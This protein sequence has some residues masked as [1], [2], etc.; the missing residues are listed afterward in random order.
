MQ[1]LAGTQ[2]RARPPGAP[3]LCLQPRPG[4]LG[5]TRPTS[6]AFTR[7]ELLV[8]LGVLALLALVVLPALA[9]NR[10]RSARVICAN[11]PRQIGMAMQL[12]GNDHD[13]RPP[14]E[15]ELADGGTRRHA[16]A[17][18]TWLHFAWLS[19]ELAS[20]QLLLCPADSGK[21]ARDFTGDPAGGY[22]HP[23]F[24]N[25]ATS[26]ALSHLDSTGANGFLAGD[27][28]LR[29][30]IGIVGCSV[31]YTGWGIGLPVSSPNDGW[32]NGLHQFAGNYLT[33][34]GAVEQADNSTLRNTLNA[35]RTDIGSTSLHFSVPR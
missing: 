29:F 21:P 7:T 1:L 16:L 9:N 32:T 17:A 20:P 22:L 13:D 31:F 34:D 25:R 28:N 19:N 23:N 5:E 6:L 30:N 35:A 18:N 4:A 27:R 14:Y 10:P 33:F 11:N 24:A 15:V 3:P 26:Y 12:W 8:V 2:G